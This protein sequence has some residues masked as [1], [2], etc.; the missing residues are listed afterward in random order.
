MCNFPRLRG[1]N[2]TE[3][4]AWEIWQVATWEIATWEVAI[5]KMPL[6]KYLTPIKVHLYQT[7]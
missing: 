7:S 4:A 5:E 6:G 3:V 2:L 1:H